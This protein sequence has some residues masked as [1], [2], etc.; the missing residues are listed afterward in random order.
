MTFMQAKSRLTGEVDRGRVAVLGLKMKGSRRKH[1]K[2][3]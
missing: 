1:G 3:K 2:C